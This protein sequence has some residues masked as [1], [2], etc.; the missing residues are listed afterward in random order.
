MEPV[1]VGVIGCGDIFNKQY[2]KCAAQYPILEIAACAD[3][4]MDKARHAAETHNIPRVCSVD[5]LLADPSIEVVLNLT[6]PAAHVPVGLQAVEAGKHVFSE[7]PFGIS[8]SEGQQLIDAAAAKGLRLGCAP[9][10]FL[11]T[12]HQT[13]RLLIDEGAIGTPVAALALFLSRGPEHWHPNPEFY[14]APGGGPM[15][16]MGPY[17]LTALTN[18]LGPMQ[19]V[20]GMAGIQ[21]PDRV[22]GK[23]AP[24][25][26]GNKIDVKTPDHVAGHIAYTSGAIATIVTSFATAGRTDDGRHP[27]TIFGT[28]GTLAVPDPNGFDGSI[29]LQPRGEKEWQEIAP[30][31]DHPNG[32]SLGL[33][34]MCHAIRAERAHRASG[35]LAFAVLA[36]MEGFLTSS[37]RGAPVEINAPA[38]RPEVLSVGLSDGVLEPAAAGERR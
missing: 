12:S 37:E 21:I 9:D 29:L 7:K 19:R 18:L 35:E 16:D 14:Y 22:V 34:E 27:I 8:V 33:A 15:F 38:E 28:E 26:E 32:R 6:I 5:E 13:C 10:T 11:G 2:A 3:L 1:K 31:H 4:D 23:G 17:Y 30:R 24:D 25:R 20:T 36:A